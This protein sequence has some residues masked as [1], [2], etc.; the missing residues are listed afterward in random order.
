MLKREFLGWVPIDE[1]N[2]E[3][4]SWFDPASTLYA[5]KNDAESSFC[6]KAKQVKILLVIEDMESTPTDT[7]NV[8]T[9]VPPPSPPEVPENKNVPA[10]RKVRRHASRRNY[11]RHPRD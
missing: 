10:A 8:T 6:C 3:T 4:L 11:G 9:N 5:S 2:E 7:P 1:D